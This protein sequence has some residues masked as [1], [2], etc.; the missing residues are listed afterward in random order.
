LWL[1]HAPGIAEAGA[2]VAGFGL[3]LVFPALGVEAVQ[4]VPPASRGSA[5]GVYT[6]F[7]DLSLGISGPISGIV[8]SAAGYRSI[9]LFAALMSLSSMALLLWLYGRQ[10]MPTHGRISSTY[11]QPFEL[12]AAPSKTQQS[13]RS[14]LRIIDCLRQGED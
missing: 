9:F 8:A 12:T 3:S 2:A 1:V 4:K 6:A 11:R 13:H 7:V 5:L 14:K 10:F